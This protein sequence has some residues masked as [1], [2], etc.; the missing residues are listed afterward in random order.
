LANWADSLIF[1]LKEFVNA[2]QGIVNENFWQRICTSES[3]RNCDDNNL[4]G[5]FMVFSPFNDKGKY[6]LNRE[7]NNVYCEIDDCGIPDCEFDF[8]FTATDKQCNHHLVTLF[9]GL[10]MTNYDININTLNALCSYT[11]IL[12]KQITIKD[13]EE[14]IMK[15]FNNFDTENINIVIAIVKFLIT[16]VQLPSQYYLNVAQSFDNTIN[17]EYFLDALRKS[18]DSQKLEIVYSIVSHGK[19]KRYFSEHS[20]DELI[21]NYFQSNK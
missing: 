11:I 19:M 16:T 3:H 17:S 13:I 7:N 21:Q 12:S 9:G 18:S 8:N 10:T 2:Y 1:V 14:Y 20:K 5:W 6:L 15:K 4:R